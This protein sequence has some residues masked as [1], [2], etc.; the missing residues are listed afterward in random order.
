MEEKFN[1]KIRKEWI[2][3]QKEKEKINEKI[4]R[5]VERE[6]SKYR[7]QFLRLQKREASY[8][9]RIEEL[10]RRLEKATTEE[11]GGISEEKLHEI[12]ITEFGRYGDEIEKIPK[13][14]GGADFIQKVIYNGK[15]CGR[16]LY[17]NKNTVSWDGKWIDKIKQDKL[18][19]KAQYAILVTNV[20]PKGA[21][22]L[23]TID[24]IQ[25]VHSSVVVYVANMI[26]EALIELEKQ[27]LSEV[28]KETKMAELYQYIISDEFRASI[29]AIFDSVKAL[30]E[31]RQSE[32]RT[33]AGI[34]AKEEQETR[35][36]NL[37][38]SK[39]MSKFKLIIEKEPKPTIIKKKE[40]ELRV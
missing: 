22:Y 36:I 13:R 11:L 10:K 4:S 6:T 23:T 9:R 7:E 20:F 12:L 26:R 30:D 15:E 17:E 38:L 37:N 33:H 31:I 19:H 1:E 40:K 2:K 24:G 3:I 27:A 28:E 32:Q 25:V 29:A 16:I 14:R 21:K 35:N 5:K 18:V 8:L 39:I 34:W